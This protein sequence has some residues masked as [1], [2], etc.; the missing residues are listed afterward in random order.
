MSNENW[1]VGN[2]K[3]EKAFAKAKM[4]VQEIDL[5]FGEYPHS[6]QDNTIYGRT[7]DGSVYGFD[8]HR[9][10]FRIEIEENNYLKTSEYSGDQIRKSC[11]GKLSVNGVQCYETS[12]RNYESCYRSIQKFI[13]DMEMNWN[14]FPLNPEEKVGKIIGYR[15]QLFKIERVIVDQGC[16]ILKTIDGKPRA[17]FLYEEGEDYDEPNTVKV[18]ITSEAIT[19]YPR[20]DK[21]EKIDAKNN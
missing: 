21:I 17:K 20:I 2:K 12:H 5:I 15:E 9:L 11:S 14:W 6:R 3:D 4:G 19:W 7:R 16:F 18:D 8:G 1:G 13:A 10:C